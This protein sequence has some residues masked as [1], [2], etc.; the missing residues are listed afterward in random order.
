MKQDKFLSYLSKRISKKFDQTV[1]RKKVEQPLTPGPDSG[2]LYEDIADYSQKTGKRFRM[3][4]AEKDSGLS[5]EEAFNQRFN[6][7]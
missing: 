1:G 7:D 2:K 6:N 3:T 5:R 4:K